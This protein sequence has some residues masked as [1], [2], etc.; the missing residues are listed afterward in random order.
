MGT[1]VKFKTT[2]GLNSTS[3]TMTGITA[4]NGPMTGNLTIMGA[5]DMDLSTSNYFTKTIN[6]NS[7]FTFSN[8]PL[9]G[10]VIGW[11]LELTHTSGTP[12]WPASVIWPNNNTVPTFTAAKR[13]LVSFITRD[14]GTTVFGS[15]IPNY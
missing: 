14:G 8:I 11:T 5:L 4:V 10:T 13:S 2:D 9:T 7:T 1:R 12:T 6:G 15:V 3:A